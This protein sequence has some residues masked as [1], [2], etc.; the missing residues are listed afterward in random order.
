MGPALL[1]VVVLGGTGLLLFVWERFRPLRRATR[2]LLTRLGVNVVISSL[3]MATAGVAV[4][5]VVSHALAW[6]SSDR[7][8]LL[9]ALG[10]PAL[11]RWVAAVLFLDLGF[12]YWHRANHAWPMLWRFHNVHHVDPDL[13]VST[14]LRFHL[15]EVAFSAA[16]R[17]LQVL[18][19]GPPFLAYMAY[20]IAFQAN[21]LFHHSNVRLPLGLERALNLVLVT[22]RMHGVHHS[23]VRG[24]T[25][26]NYSV[27]FP[28]WDWL[29]RSLVLAIRQREITIGIPGYSRPEDNRVFALLTMPFRG[30]RDYWGQQAR[31][32]R[33]KPS[34][35]SQMLD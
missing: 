14:A 21:T 10:L 24:E 11:G 5:P 2:P 16:F 1:S 6:T 3:A 26:S 30:Q 22:P 12:Y 20:E 19:I 23:H 29:H 9:A 8:G 31:P 25:N 18:L 34:V 4:R 15:G 28:W 33:V 13:D 35:S 27:V 32:A 7:V 17:A